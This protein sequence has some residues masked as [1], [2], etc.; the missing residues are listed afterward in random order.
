MSRFPSCINV[1]AVIAFALTVLGALQARA[2]EGKD[3][4]CP[5][6]FDPAF[7]TQTAFLKE[8]NSKTRV[9]ETCSGITLS[10]SAHKTLRITGPAPL[11]LGMTLEVAHDTGSDGFKADSFCRTK[12]TVLGSRGEGAA[13]NFDEQINFDVT[14][15]GVIA[16]QT[17]PYKE[18]ISTFP[19]VNANPISIEMC[20]ADLLKIAESYRVNCEFD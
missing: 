9:E 18:L 17:S 3:V 6:L 1:V 5:C 12:W 15:Y 19:S 16:E 8:L 14:Y 20:E 10:R 7:W 13:I 2:E 4:S 11:G